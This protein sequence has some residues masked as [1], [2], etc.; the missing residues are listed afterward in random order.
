MVPD[1]CVAVVAPDVRLVGRLQLGVSAGGLRTQRERQ[2][3]ESCY[4]Y[5]IR[6]RRLV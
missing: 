1:R 6:H 2:E 4:L 5:Y 3:G